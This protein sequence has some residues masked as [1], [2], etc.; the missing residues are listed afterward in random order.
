M[1]EINRVRESS[2]DFSQ[3]KVPGSKFQVPMAL[4]K[5]EMGFLKLG[6]WVLELGILGLNAWD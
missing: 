4:E 2:K 5:I 1:A 6:T 3:K